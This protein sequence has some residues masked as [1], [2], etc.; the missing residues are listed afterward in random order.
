MQCKVALISSVPVMQAFLEGP[1][2]SIRRFQFLVFPSWIVRAN[3]KDVDGS[4]MFHKALQQ[5]LVLVSEGC[6]MHLQLS[7]KSVDP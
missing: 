6:P 2:R 4:I 3:L 7:L 1:S 5:N